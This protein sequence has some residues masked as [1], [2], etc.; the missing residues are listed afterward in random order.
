MMSLALVRTRILLRGDPGA[1]DDAADCWYGSPRDGT[2]G[3][4]G[5]TDSLIYKHVLVV[6]K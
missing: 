3:C 6:V 4:D 5:E 1:A 2:R